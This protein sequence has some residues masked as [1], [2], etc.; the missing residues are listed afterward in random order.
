MGRPKFI[1]FTKLRG[2]TEVDNL[3]LEDYIIIR[4]AYGTFTHEGNFPALEK[5][6]ITCLARHHG[7][8]NHACCAVSG[9]PQ[10][11]L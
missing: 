8:R 5:N 4:I 9:R 10:L 1:R 7:Y 6:S 11:G 3:P 2:R